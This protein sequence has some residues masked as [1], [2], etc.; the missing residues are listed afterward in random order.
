[1]LVY[2]LV[3]SDKT[4]NGVYSSKNKLIT[5]LTSSLASITIDKIEV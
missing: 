1:M 3:A 2:V 5:D 4:I